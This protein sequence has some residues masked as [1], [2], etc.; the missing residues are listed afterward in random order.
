LKVRLI[1]LFKITQLDSFTHLRHLFASFLRTDDDD[2]TVFPTTLP[3]LGRNSS[4]LSE[5]ACTAILKEH[6]P[7]DFELPKECYRF[8]SVRAGIIR[9]NSKKDDW[10]IAFSGMDPGSAIKAISAREQGHP[11]SAQ[12]TRRLTSRSKASDASWF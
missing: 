11:H 2:S 6:L 8:S 7:P 9:R 12:I 10:N 3:P 5:S 4:R 1:L